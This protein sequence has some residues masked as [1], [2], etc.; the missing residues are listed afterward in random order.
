VLLNF[1][2][3]IRLTILFLPFIAKN[4]L[5]MHYLLHFQMK[6]QNLKLKAGKTEVNTKHVVKKKGKKLNLPNQERNSNSHY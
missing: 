6:E 5:K 1:Y 3:E 4:S 2:K